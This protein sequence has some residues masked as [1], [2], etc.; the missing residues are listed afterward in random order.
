MFLVSTSPRT[1]AVP[2]DDQDFTHDN[3]MIEI[4]A[5]MRILTVSNTAWL[6]QE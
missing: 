2:T 1:V 5:A 3:E 6:G 4:V